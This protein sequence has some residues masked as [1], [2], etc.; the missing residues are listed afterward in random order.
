MKSQKNQ[1][2][3][4][5]KQIDSEGVFS[6]YASVFDIIDSHNDVIINGAFSNSLHKNN[7]KLLWQHQID[8]P[9]GNIT[10]LKEDSY[11]L[12]VEGKLLL[13]VKKGREAYSMLK[14]GAINSMSIGYSVKDAQFDDQTGLRYSVL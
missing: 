2:I 10:S 11:G 13:D 6:G 7:V 12:F 3:F 1:Y 9:I 5:V 14:S 8:A 4:D